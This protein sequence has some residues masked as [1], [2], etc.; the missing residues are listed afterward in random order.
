MDRGAVHVID[1][2]VIQSYAVSVMGLW[3]HR[4]AVG[5]TM[6]K[7]LQVPEGK[8]VLKEGDEH[9]CIFLDVCTFLPA[10]IGYRK[11]QA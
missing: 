10:C 11:S 3:I 1:I 6:G 4:M 2:D 8:L 9:L 7:D 5:K